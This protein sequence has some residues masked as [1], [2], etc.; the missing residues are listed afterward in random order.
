MGARS[1]AILD[2]GVTDE[3]EAVYGANGYEYEY[4]Y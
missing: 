1:F 3:T 4:Y 2:S